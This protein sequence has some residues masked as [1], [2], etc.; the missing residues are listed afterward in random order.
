MSKY[1]FIKKVEEMIKTE[2][3]AT[4]RLIGPLLKY[5]PGK[6]QAK[7][8]ENSSKD[9]PYL[10]FVVDPYSTFLFYELIDLDWARRLIPDGFEL[11]KTRVFSDG[12]PKYYIAFASFNVKTSAFAGTRLEV[13][14]IARSKKTGLI[15][16]I[17]VDYDTNTLSHD[18]LKG[19]IDSTTKQAIFTT[20]Y[21]GNIIV[22]ISNPERNRALIFDLDSN[23]A[24]YKTVEKSFWLEGN[25]SV[26][27][28]RDI[29]KNSPAAFAMKFDPREVEK[30]CR[31]DVNKINSI[32]NTW[33][34]G[35]FNKQ[36]DEALYFPFAQH[37]LS[38]SPG[39]Y[40]EHDHVD[41]MIKEF[42]NLDLDSIPPYSAEALRKMVKIGLISNSVVITILLFIILVLLIK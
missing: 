41:E 6:F 23:G 42:E 8:M 19:V 15:S 5:V 38:D 11:E 17:I 18:A 22:D 39:N 33:Y 31:V 26:G 25:L 37:Y 30:A 2:D 16:W 20:D 7:A 13:N 21:E 32:E 36:V 24:E 9:N 14:V 10:G 29:S 35:L 3:I 4:L 1:K 40:S 34:P 28:G 27:Y 12:Q